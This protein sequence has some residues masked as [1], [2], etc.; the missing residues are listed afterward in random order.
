MTTWLFDELQKTVCTYS[1]DTELKYISVFSVH[2]SME[3]EMDS[4]LRRYEEEM[5]PWGLVGGGGVGGGGGG[6]GRGLKD[7]Q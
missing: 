4:S 2:V 1:L 3:S 5:P 6:G 7:I